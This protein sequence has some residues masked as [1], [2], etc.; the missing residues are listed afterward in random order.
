MADINTVAQQFCKYYYDTFDGGRA[1]LGPLYRP[2]SMLT[3]EGAPTMGD[4]AIVEKLAGLPFQSV[5]HRIATQ[6]AQPLDNGILINVTGQLLIDGENN[7]QFF[8]QTFHLK[9][10]SGSFYVQNDIFRLVYA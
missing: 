3:F 10:D 1:N 7:P 5:I 9:P 2:S 8:C 6:D 4:A